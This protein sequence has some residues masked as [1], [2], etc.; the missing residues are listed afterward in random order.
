MWRG[1]RSKWRRVGR[2]W[3]SGW[4]F[5]LSNVVEWVN[6]MVENWEGRGEPEEKNLSNGLGDWDSGGLSVDQ[7][8]WEWWRGA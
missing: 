8:G 5:D 1:W 7:K 2:G 4:G 6:G 3:I